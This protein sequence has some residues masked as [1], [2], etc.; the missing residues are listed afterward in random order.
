MYG[1]FDPVAGFLQKVILGQQNPPNLPGFS[2]SHTVPANSNTH[3]GSAIYLDD[4]VGR[5]IVTLNTFLQAVEVL[6]Y[7]LKQLYTFFWSIIYLVKTSLR[8]ILIL[9]AFSLSS[10]TRFL[11]IK[12]QMRYI[13]A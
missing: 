3:G 10:S 1:S 12:I 6:L 9:S 13:N 4:T 8:L 11:F 5:F 2:M 7:F